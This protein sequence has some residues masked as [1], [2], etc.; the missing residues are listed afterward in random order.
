MPGEA[1]SYLMVM[2]AE[3]ASLIFPRSRVCAHQAGLIR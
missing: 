1:W 2:V 3:Y